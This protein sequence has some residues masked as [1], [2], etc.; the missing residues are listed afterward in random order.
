[1][2]VRTVG[3][4]GNSRDGMVLLT[5]AQHPNGCTGARLALSHGGWS[6]GATL[7]A[8]DLVRLER[9]CAMALE[10]FGATG[11]DVDLLRERFAARHGDEDIVAGLKPRPPAP[12]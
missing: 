9:L 12:A 2:S 7:G 8:A 5:L 11:T 6:G 10:V 4:L 1:M 3:S